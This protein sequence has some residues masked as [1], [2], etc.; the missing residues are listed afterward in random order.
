MFKVTD[1]NRTERTQRS[2]HWQEVRPIEREGVKETHTNG[3]RQSL[4]FRLVNGFCCFFFA[5]FDGKEKKKRIK[6]KQRRSLDSESVAFPM[7]CPCPIR[8]ERV[9]EGGMKNRRRGVRAPR[10]HI[11]SERWG[12]RAARARARVR[13]DR[14][15]GGE[16]GEGEG[17]KEH[18]H[19]PALTL[20]R[21]TT[22]KEKNLRKKK[23]EREADQE[24][25]TEDC[26]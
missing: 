14:L 7:L 9:R 25:R 8:C 21:G 11:Y 23:S 17:L 10:F 20:N 4:A 15:G 24:W 3:W 12:V 2:W 1:T 16:V 6:T 13:G 5:P 22:T 26:G 19:S 18:R